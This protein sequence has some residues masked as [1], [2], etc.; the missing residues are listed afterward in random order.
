MSGVSGIHTGGI[1]KPDAVKTAIPKRIALFTGSYNHIADGVSLTLNRLVDHLEKNG[2]EVLVL[3]PTSEDPPIEHKGTLAAVPS[4]A[5]PGRPEYRV[6]VG[7]PSHLKRRLR[8][9]RP[10]LFHIATPDILGFKALKLAHSWGIPVVASFHTHFG[11]YLKYYNLGVI[12]DLL[13]KYGRWFYQ[14]CEHIYVPSQSMV[15]VL[16]M[17]G[18]EKGVKLWPRGVDMKVFNPGK[19]SIEWRRQFGIADHEVL[20]SFVSRLVWEK[21]LDVFADVIETLSR[22]GVPH[23]SIIVGDGPASELLEKRLPGTIFAGYRRG[24]DLSAAYASS[25]I[26]LFP[27]ETETFGNVTLEAMASGVPTV[28]ADALGSRSLVNS[29]I[30]G[31]LAPPADSVSFTNHVRDLVRNGDLRRELGQNAY[32]HAQN[33]SWEAILTRINGYYDEMLSAKALESVDDE[34]GPETGSRLILPHSSLPLSA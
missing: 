4:F 7:F 15:D 33:Y 30:T 34:S 3:A 32:Q 10:N 12:E 31:Y 24:E 2:A 19:R 13:W 11:S 6:A 28:C 20:I 21:G 26:F 29:G 8:E 25:D 27:S 14:K 5:A 1:S 23:R 17:R 16:R 22:E 9:F 18:I